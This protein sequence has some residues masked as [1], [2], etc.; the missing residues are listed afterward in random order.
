MKRI[1]K[2][3]PIIFPAM[4]VLAACDESVS[5]TGSSLVEGETQ[6][7]DQEDFTVTGVSTPNNSVR[8]RTV[9]QLLG[10]LSAEG[11][12]D[13]S[14]DIVCQYMPAANIDTFECFRS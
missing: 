11:Y 1:S 2:L 14:S 8:S 9:L 13:F 7:I 6:I 12:G 4:I 10:R 3:L 5:Q